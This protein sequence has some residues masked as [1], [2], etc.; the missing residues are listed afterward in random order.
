MKPRVNFNYL[1]KD[2][3]VDRDRDRDRDKL[4]DIAIDF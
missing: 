2:I 3:D 1:K 4:R